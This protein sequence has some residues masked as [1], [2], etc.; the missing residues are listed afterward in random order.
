MNKPSWFARE[1]PRDF[2]Y[3]RIEVEGDDHLTIWKLLAAC[4]V[5]ALLWIG[6]IALWSLT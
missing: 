3:G 6:I 5:S 4:I 1:L 2:G